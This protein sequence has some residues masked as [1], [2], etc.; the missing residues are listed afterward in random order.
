MHKSFGNQ[1]PISP[2]QFQKKE[3]TMCS[4]CG[5]FGHLRGKCYKLIGYPLGHKFGKWKPPLANAVG[6]AS[7]GDSSEILNSLSHLTITPSQC[8]QVLSVLVPKF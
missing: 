5:M 2:N 4:Y 1:R 3:R 8:Q 7:H 6:Q